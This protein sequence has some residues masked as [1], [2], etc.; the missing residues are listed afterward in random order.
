VG[1]SRLSSFNCANKAAKHMIKKSK[2]KYKNT[3]T[4]KYIQKHN[5]NLESTS[6]H[7]DINAKE[8]KL[9]YSVCSL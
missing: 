7:N 6:D 9:F 1:A 2:L 3:R 4:Q 8:A 5:R